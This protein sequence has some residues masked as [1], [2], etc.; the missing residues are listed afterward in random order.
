MGEEPGGQ[1]R[2]DGQF[3]GAEGF[4]DK[5]GLA[6]VFSSPLGNVS[7]DD[8]ILFSVG[9]LVKESRVMVAADNEGSSHGG[10][11]SAGGLEEEAC[12]AP[13]ET[14]DELK[15][16]PGRGLELLL[17][18]CLDGFEEPVVC[19][20]TSLSSGSSALVSASICSVLLSTCSSKVVPG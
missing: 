15:D 17:E 11:S 1:W 7:G 2:S 12:S 16:E 10:C 14:L 4:F 20:V 19:V 18:S 8:A 5:S 3:S 9:T 6:A 13:G